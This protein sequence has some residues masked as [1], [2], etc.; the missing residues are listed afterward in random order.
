MTSKARDSAAS[1]SSR[2]D[3][4]A[5]RF[6]LRQSKPSA[7]CTHHSSARFAPLAVLFRENES[8]WTFLVGSATSAQHSGE[9][10][11]NCT[12][13]GFQNHK[14]LRPFG[15][16]NLG[17]PLKGTCPPLNI[18]KN[19]L[20]LAWPTGDVYITREILQIRVEPENPSS[21]WAPSASL[22]GNNP[23]VIPTHPT[24]SEPSGTELGSVMMRPTSRD[25]A[26]MGCA[27]WARMWLAQ[28]ASTI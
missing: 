8:L 11:D 17:T 25:T 3:L 2:L 16:M 18:A 23:C 12:L 15:G 6:L 26:W 22:Q 9:S 24:P 13:P 28:T 4:G 5:I 14:D 1:A 7:G 20:R 21:F 27:F 19:K 10:Q